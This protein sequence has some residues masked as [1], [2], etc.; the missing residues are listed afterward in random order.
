M[1]SNVDFGV[2]QK[3]PIG[4]YVPTLFG[5]NNVQICDMPKK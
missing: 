3:I 2:A 1:F 4:M 5:E